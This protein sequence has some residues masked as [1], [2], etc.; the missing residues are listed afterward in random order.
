MTNNIRKL[1][2]TGLTSGSDEVAEIEILYKESNNT[3]IY[4]IDSIKKKDFS[5]YN[6][7]AG[8]FPTTFEIKSEIIGKTIQ[9]NQL[10]RPFDNVPR[11]AKAQEIIA[12]RVVYGNYLQNYTVDKTIQL[13]VDYLS[14]RHQGYLPQ[15]SADQIDKI[16]FPE[17]S[18]KSIR[19]YQGGV[20]FK[21]EFG[22]ETPVVTN[23]NASINLPVD[24]ACDVNSLAITPSGAAPSWATHYKFF[25]KNT[26]N[27]FYNLALDRYYFAE[28]GNVWLSFPSSE[29]NKVDEETYLILK[30]QHDNFKPVKDLVRYKIL[31]I[32]SEAPDFIS[33]F[34]RSFAQD[35]VTAQT[36][37]EP[38]FTRMVFDVSGGVTNEFKNG[39]IAGNYIQITDGANATNTYLISEG[40]AVGQPDNRYSVR[41]DEPLGTDATFLLSFIADG[42]KPTIRLLRETVERKPEFEGRFFVKINRDFN[43][44]E[45][46]VAS[47]SNYEE[48]YAATGRIDIANKIVRR[49]KN[50][51]Q[52][53]CW[54]DSGNDCSNGRKLGTSLGGNG[55][56]GAKK[57]E[58]DPPIKGKDYFGVLWP[59][60]S[61]TDRFPNVDGVMAVVGAL[62]RFRGTTQQQVSEPYRVIA[63]EKKNGRRGWKVFGGD[64]DEWNDQREIA[65]NKRL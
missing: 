14:A 19:T 7:P 55:N 27:E 56:F 18:L 62:L 48:V 1:I 11:K 31:A 41:I 54:F 40:G 43:F 24:R 57:D 60:R 37:F 53:W 2:L 39:F 21:D 49:Y 63:F 42:G 20:V 15:T 38:G 4:C 65:S 33:T 44:D 36:G 45:N 22:R 35:G 3:S 6:V 10:L 61:K 16:G 50:P 30:K 59:M 17:K 52:P 25:I 5:P 12:N 64:C 13:D 58:F 46:I 23:N 26:A 47:F 29:R 51:E 28:D 34:K 32:E 8:A 9:G